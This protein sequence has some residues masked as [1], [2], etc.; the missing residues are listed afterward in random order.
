[1][2][3]EGIE[4]D[5]SDRKALANRYIAQDVKDTGGRLVAKRGDLVDSD[6]M[7]KMAA[8]KI[9]KI[10]VQSPL[11]DPTPGDG[12]SSWSYGTDY[13]GKRHNTGDHIGIISSHTITE[14]SVNM[15]MKSFHTGGAFD[16]AKRS[17]GTYFDALDRTLRFTQNLPDKGT[18][19]SMDSVV[20]SVHPSSIGGFDV[21]LK[22][23]NIEEARYI[24][25]GNKITVKTGQPVKRGDQLDDG[26][27]S[28][29]DMLKYRGMRDTQKF[30]V[31]R[32]DTL[33]DQKLDKRDIETIVRGITNTTRVMHPGSSNYITG[34]LAPL[35][36]IEW[37]N[38]NNKHE[39]DVESVL[40]DHFA[41]NQ[42]GYKK[43]VKID[44]LIIKDLR[45]KGVKRVDVFKD[46]IKHEPFLTPAGI[47]AKAQ[48]G[49][50]WI[51]RLA[52]NRI[53]QVLEEG[54]TQGW[55]SIAS[56]TGHPIPQYITGEY[57]W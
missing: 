33:T 36:T 34:D 4:Y 57:T 30:L 37:Y 25:P 44:N 56:N 3:T 12:F 49:E 35:S 29:H 1:V 5:I 45:K 16:L 13:T 18:L 21:V 27:P 7:N 9:S 51:A 11:T 17:T 55:K 19:A 26:I 2:D 10:F 39:E 40:G 15:A 50:D 52:H 38:N 23:G 22:N 32:I 28:P 43:N 54:T 8:R 31:N 47:G 46:R 53:K 20:K 24:Q 41:D 48:T 6:V 14:P 42:Y